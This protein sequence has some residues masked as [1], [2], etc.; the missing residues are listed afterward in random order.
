MNVIAF[1]VLAVSCT[2]IASRIAS[3]RLT[4][5]ERV[6]AVI[7]YLPMIALALFVLFGYPYL[8]P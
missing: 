2:G 3:N 4:G 1:C 6:F 5:A 8:A 7:H